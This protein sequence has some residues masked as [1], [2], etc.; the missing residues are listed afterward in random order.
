MGQGTSN[1]IEIRPAVGGDAQDLARLLEHLGYPAD[2]RDLPDR[3]S[4]LESSG[5]AATLVATLDGVVVGLATVH[6][7][8][9][10]HH[11]APVVPLTALHRAEAPVFYERLG[12]EHTGRRYVKSLQ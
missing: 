1:A 5:D 3:L 10:L 2:P 8:T 12:F 9:V 7:R 11:E 4:R 6:G